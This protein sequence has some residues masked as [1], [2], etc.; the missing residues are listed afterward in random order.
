MLSFMFYMPYF[1]GKVT[2]QCYFC[3][4]FRLG[5]GYWSLVIVLGSWAALVSSIVYAVVNALIR[6][7]TVI[8]RQVGHSG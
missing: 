1:A 5:F 3:L 6:N 7:T 2:I 4:W 8:T